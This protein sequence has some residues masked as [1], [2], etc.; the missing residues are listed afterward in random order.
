MVVRC[1]A[2]VAAGEEVVINYL[3]RT[4]LTPLS[5]RQAELEACYGFRCDC[6]RCV[7]VP[8]CGVSPVG[9]L[10]WL[11]HTASQQYASGDACSVRHNREGGLRQC[12]PWVAAALVRSTQY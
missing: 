8:V 9:V 12:R 6:S 4:A 7:L 10:C 2:P 3:G 5:Q 1:C 11:L